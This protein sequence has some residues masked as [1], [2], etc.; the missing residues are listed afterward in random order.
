MRY[1][2]VQP[3][4]DRLYLKDVHVRALAT[5][6]EQGV[7]RTVPFGEADTWRKATD[8][9]ITAAE[10]TLQSVL[11]DP[12]AVAVW[13][14]VKRELT[15]GEARR[16]FS[17]LIKEMHFG[18]RPQVDAEK[19]DFAKI[20]EYVVGWSIKDAAGGSVP[21]STAAL[22]NVNV[23]TFNDISAA[24]DWHEAQAAVA[25]EARKNEKADTT[26]S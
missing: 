6:R 19:L 2:F 4:V 26:K 3:D 22:Q 13:V 8:A 12:D 1:G 17:Q 25:L 18:E 5:L 10:A 16:A 7:K 23:A 24:V 9:E 15:A 21:F 20:A 11:D 14:D